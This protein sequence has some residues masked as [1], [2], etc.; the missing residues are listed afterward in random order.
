MVV[1]QQLQLNRIERTLQQ[2]L[3]NS[4]PSLDGGVA[5][6][7]TS[8]T[9]PLTAPADEYTKKGTIRQR[10]MKRDI[11]AMLPD[12]AIWSPH[13]KSAREYWDEFQYGLNGAVPLKDMEAKYGASWRSDTILQKTKGIKTSALRTGWSKRLPIYSLIIHRMA[14]GTT[15]MAAVEEVEQVFQNHMTP[16]TRNPMLHPISVILR[17]RLKNENQKVGL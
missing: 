4:L 17:N 8:Q 13:L 16:V 1:L 5:V 14:N 3:K 2:L 12:G 6:S 9:Q 15:E 11:V 7:P 10:K